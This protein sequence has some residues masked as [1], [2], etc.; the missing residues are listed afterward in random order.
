M[1]AGEPRRHPTVQ[2]STKFLDMSSRH[3]QPGVLHFTA[4][5]LKLSSNVQPS[6]PTSWLSVEADAEAPHRRKEAPLV[7]NIRTNHGAGIHGARHKPKSEAVLA[8]PGRSPI[9]VFTLSPTVGGEATGGLP[10]EL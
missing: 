8:R 6:L 4:G 7:S 5:Y 2:L 3:A 1:I 10:G 9:N